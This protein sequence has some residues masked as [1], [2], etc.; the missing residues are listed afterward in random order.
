MLIVCYSP[1]ATCII[2][3]HFYVKYSCDDQIKCPHSSHKIF[4]HKA[5]KVRLHFLRLWLMVF[6]FQLH[7][8]SKI[9]HKFLTFSLLPSP[10][11]LWRNGNLINSSYCT[12]GQIK[13]S[14]ASIPDREHSIESTRVLG[15]S[16]VLDPPIRNSLPDWSGQVQCWLKVIFH[17]Q[18][19]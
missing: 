16:G 5:L 10:P 3:E 4:W 15:Q 14:N 18:S 9:W 12:R 13:N 2:A 1:G 11:S 17:R 19:R 8:P 6:Q 7:H